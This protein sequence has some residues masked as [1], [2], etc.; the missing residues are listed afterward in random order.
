MAALR[1][2]LGPDILLYRSTLMLKPSHHRSAHG[3][4][5]DSAYWPMDPPVSIT[6]SIALT[7]ATPENGCFKVIP[8]SHQWG[9]QEWGQ[10][11][12]DKGDGM[13]DRT[14]VDLSGQIEVPMRAGSALFLHSKLVH[15]SGPNMSTNPRNTALYVYFP[16]TVNYKPLH[17]EDPK[18]LTFR[19]I[20]G[21]GGRQKI[22]MTAV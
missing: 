1:K 21:A 9:L 18:S 10:I 16:T 20:C 4:H 12:R 5:Q 15:G 19:V 3:F 22:T 13:T 8:G 14:D 2:L 7:E 6:L 11:W 17:A